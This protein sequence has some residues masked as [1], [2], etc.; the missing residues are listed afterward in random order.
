MES[1]F[2]VDKLESSFGGKN[3]AKFDFKEYAQ[4]MK[5]D[6]ANRLASCHK[7]ESSTSSVLGLSGRSSLGS[8][9]NHANTDSD[10]DGEKTKSLEINEE[11]MLA[12]S[13]KI[14]DSDGGGIG[15]R[16]ES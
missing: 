2:Y 3:M 12:E 9:F 6:D 5:D 7:G 14:S 13:K 15:G 11:E 4:R 8:E 16:I 1:L 10:S